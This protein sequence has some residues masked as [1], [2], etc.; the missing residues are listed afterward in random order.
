MAAA[1]K[2]VTHT[3]VLIVGGGPVGLGLAADLGW[4]GVACTVVEQGDGSIAHP[5]ATAEN[6]RTMELFRRWGI[7]ERV[8]EAGTPPDFPHTVLYLTSLTGYEIARIDRPGHGGTARTAISPERPQRCNQLWLDPILR[9][10][11]TSFPTVTLKLR[12]R[13]ELF[14]EKD[15]R[16]VATVTDLAS[17]E[18]HT[19]EADYLVACCGGASS[20]QKTLGIAMNGVPTLDYNLNIFFR[21]K[22]LWNY[23]DK[24]KGAL[25]FFADAQ[26]IWRTLVQIDGRELWRLGIRGQWHY[27]NPDKVD[28]SA[29]INEMVGREIPHEVVASLPWVA[30]DLVADHY[31][32]GRVFL[33]GDAAHQNTPS[34]GFGL[35]T[36]MGDVNDLGWKLAGLVQGWGGPRLIDCYEAERRPVAARIVKQATDNFMRDRKRP[37]HPEIAMDTPAGAEARRAMG[38]AILESQSKVYLTD[39][40]ALG[41]V[42]D[43]SPI[44]CDD[45]TP[46]PEASVSE[47]RP[48][49]RP[50]AR[51]PHAWLADGRSTLD[52]FGRGF[53]LVKLGADAPDSSAFES[54][55]ASRRVPLSVV[56]LDDP[57][58]SALYERRLVLVRPDGHVAWRGDTPPSDPLAVVDRV[59]G[60]M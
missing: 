32:N 13:F 4:R 60:A 53:T 15:G 45:G 49:T 57:E 19:I 24:G 42:Y 31:G 21:V 5:R 47:Y 7:A 22:E 39:G 11:A 29:M 48:T 59:R 3:P 28:A 58:I 16:I 30:R 36:G 56:S 37:S 26:G 6:A 8:K 12:T 20:I 44:V 35:N 10:F 27:E 2:S 33:A 25:H 41:Q 52:L 17:G 54:A 40:T 18:T 9:D 1:S 23:H 38:A 55:F 14:V 50:G 46:P 43:N 34:G 51:A